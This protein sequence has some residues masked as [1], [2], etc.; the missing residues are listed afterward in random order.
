MSKGRTDI[1]M[2]LRHR[3][4]TVIIHQ[5]ILFGK[6]CLREYNEA[7]LA[8]EIINFKRYYL[9]LVLHA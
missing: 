1:K 3:W 7:K 8:N 6:V 5:T 4:Q 2:S 9:L